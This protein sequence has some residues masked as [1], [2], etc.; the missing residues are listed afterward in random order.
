MKKI[1]LVVIA[2]AVAFPML[3]YCGLI[4][5][6]NNGNNPNPPPD[7]HELE[8]GN[9]FLSFS[10]NI[11]YNLSQSN[12]PFTF[13]LNQSSGLPYCFMFDIT[14]NSVLSLTIDGADFSVS[15]GVARL[16][17]SHVKALETDGFEANGTSCVGPFV[18]VKVWNREHESVR[19]RIEGWE[20]VYFNRVKFAV[21]GTC[22][23]RKLLAPTPLCILEMK[24]VGVRNVTNV[25]H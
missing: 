24:D 4:T 16:Q 20:T 23:P 22:Y 18:A 2:A 14:S 17:R 5:W 11:K 7:C 19:W 8:I 13:R 6:L 12:L 3:G 10:G 15:N 1:I 9:R 21:D 25:V